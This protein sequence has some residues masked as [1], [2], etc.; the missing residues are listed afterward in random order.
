MGGFGAGTGVYVEVA[1]GSSWDW[2][3]FE[4]VN[5][6]VLF[7]VLHEYSLWITVV[8]STAHLWMKVG[9]GQLGHLHTPTQSSHCYHFPAVVTQFGHVLLCFA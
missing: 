7:F 1:V 3:E 6:M 8:H 2:M 9:K 4:M 5:A